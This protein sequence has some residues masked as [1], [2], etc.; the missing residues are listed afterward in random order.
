MLIFS[1]IGY[2]SKSITINSNTK[3][4]FNVKLKP[5]TKTLKE[6]T[7]KSKKARYSRKNNPAVE[8]MKKVIAAKKQTD[9]DNRD[10]YQYN[11]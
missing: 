9:L 5:D 4:N 11:K 3:N 8:L 1:A 7:I 2:V 6:V 10:V